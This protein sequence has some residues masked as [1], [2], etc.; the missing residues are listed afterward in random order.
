MRVAIKTLLLSSALAVCALP[1]LAQSQGD[2]TFGI[3]VGS[4]DPKSDNGPLAGNPADIASDEALTLTFEYFIRDNIGIELLAATPFEH[5]ISI[6]N[7]GE[8]STKHLPP[9]LSVNYHFTNASPWKP[10]VGAGINYTTFFEE[11]TNL[12]TL[13]LDDSFGI[14]VQVGVDYKISDN[15]WLRANVRWFDIDTE[16]TLDGAD[17]GT[18]EI[19]PFLFGVAY[20]HKF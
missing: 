1:A 15:G 4:I 8:A 14:S 20:V 19:D 13:E 16:A 2:W 9:T 18:A 10:Y 12:G 6:A 3:G 11:E 5:G 17:I 7:V